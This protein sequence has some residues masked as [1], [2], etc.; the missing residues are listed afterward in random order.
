VRW[1]GRR[2]SITRDGHLVGE[3]A[4]EPQVVDTAPAPL[5]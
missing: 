4:V 3:T 2:F 5:A 1:R